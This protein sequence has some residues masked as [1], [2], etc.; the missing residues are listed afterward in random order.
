MARS[1][2]PNVQSE[3]SHSAASNEESANGSVSASPRSNPTR[4]PRP[5][6]SAS[7]WAERTA[8]GE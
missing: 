7:A 3:H 6:V 5:A 1:L 8:S 4:S 2:S